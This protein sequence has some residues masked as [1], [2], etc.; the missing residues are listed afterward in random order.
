T[1]EQLAQLTHDIQTLALQELGR[2]LLLAVDQEGGSVARMGPPFSQIPDAVSLGRGGCESV[3]R[4]SRLTAREMFQV[5]LNLNLAPVLDVNTSGA[6]GVMERRS[7]GDDPSL[8]TQCGIAAISATQDENIMAT[9]KHFPG[10][11]RAHNDPHHD[12]PVV[13]A[14]G[15]ELERTDLP[16]FS[17]AIQAD[18]ACVMTSHTLYPALDPENPG[19][20]SPTILRN[21]LRAQ[22]GFDG[23]LITDDLEMGAI[24]KEGDLG[25]AALQAF[26]AGADLLLICHSHEKVVAAFKKTAAAITQKPELAI[27]M[28][29]SL[30]RVQVM[31][32]KFAR[33]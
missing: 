1:P 31:R 13:S 20:F 10:L 29:E 8:V 9:A 15:E 24:E 26:A 7:F 6:A 17:A 3:R 27:R 21:L 5:G 14:E 32:E 12:L 4:Y 33:E 2:P 16:P 11:G 30:E 28:Q 19:T 25:H 18:V 22:L 23:V